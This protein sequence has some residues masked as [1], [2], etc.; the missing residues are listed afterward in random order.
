MTTNTYTNIIT[1]KKSGDTA[2]QTV[3]FFHTGNVEKHD[4]R[5][6]YMGCD[7]EQLN[8]SVKSSGFSLADG[9]TNMGDTFEEKWNDFRSR[10]VAKVFIYVTADFTGYYMNID[11]FEEFVKTWCYLS[12]ESAKN[13][14]RSKIRCKHESKKNAGMACVP[15]NRLTRG[16]ISLPRV[17]P[18]DILPIIW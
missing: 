5:A 3:N 1:C 10:V 17:N 2:Q 9:R 15:C 8:A 4:N 6:W 11:E 7:I 13:G 12:K 18:L 14:G 16:K